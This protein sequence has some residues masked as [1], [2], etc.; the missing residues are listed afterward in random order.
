LY[1]QDEQVFYPDR[2]N[3]PYKVGEF[4]SAKFKEVHATVKKSKMPH[5][6]IHWTEWN[7]QSAPSADKV[8]WGENIYV[9]NLFAA[10]FI[11]RNALEVDSICQS[12][13]YWVVSDIFD[14]GGIAASPFST[15]Y[16]LMTIHGIPKANFNAFAFL[17][18]MT[19]QVLPLSYSASPGAGKGMVAT[20]DGQRTNL[21]LYHQPFV[22][23]K[24]GKPWTAQ[25]EIP[26]SGDTSFLVVRA[27]IRPGAGSAWESWQL[28]GRPLNPTTAQLELLQQHSRPAYTAQMVPVKGK[29]VTIDITLQPGEV[30]YIEVAPLGQTTTTRFAD[31]EAFKV[32]DA[33]MSERN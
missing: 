31:P 8:T 11:V 30:V 22:E 1:P 24:P 14:E 32:W 6:E 27:S 2:K 13:A 23:E 10:S 33:G 5:L 15:T 18:K 25:V 7:T 26:V 21:L 12:M 3:S 4:F 29:P 20:R 9:D 16:G 17:R 19:G 28:M